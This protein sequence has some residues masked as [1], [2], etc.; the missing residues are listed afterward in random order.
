MDIYTTYLARD[1]ADD[2]LRPWVQLVALPATVFRLKLLLGCRGVRLD[3]SIGESRRLRQ[4][5]CV[6]IRATKTS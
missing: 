4:A 5:V 1:L 3:A 2:G 6:E